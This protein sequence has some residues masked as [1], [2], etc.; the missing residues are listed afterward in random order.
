MS[1]FKIPA[2]RTSPALD[3]IANGLMFNI[4][5]FAIVLSHSPVI[6][7]LVVLL[8]LALHFALLGRGAPELRLVAFVL[9]GGAIL[10]Q[11]L[12]AVGVFTVEGRN[13][14]APLWLTCLWPV[15]ATTL[16]HAFKGFRGRIVLCVLLGAI[17]GG[18]SYVA[19]VRLSDVEFATPLLAPAA[20]A[21]LWAVLFP[22]LVWL[23]QK[24][25]PEAP[26]ETT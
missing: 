15:F 21:L 25:V 14:L 4:S 5:W 24:L 13:G 10:D 11:L 9:L 1:A 26:H 6:G 2:L 17:G 12:F 23:G 3:A 19:G 18:G 20:V 22:A 7:P 16:T 8:H